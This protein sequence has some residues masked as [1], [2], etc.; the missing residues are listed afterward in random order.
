[1]SRSHVRLT[2]PQNDAELSAVKALFEDYA[3]S[4]NFSLAFQDFEQEMATFPAK[5]APPTGALILATVDD[6]PAGAVA[7][8]Q[9]APSI[10]E[11][12]RLY[13]RP[14]FRGHELGRK[15]AEAIVAEGKS[16]GYRA[17]RLDTFK[18][19]MARAKALYE[20]MGFVE[21]EP[22][23]DNPMPDVCYMEMMLR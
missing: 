19:S 17:M 21:V 12:K 18:D 4:L 5:Y 8:W 3:R 16:L 23:Y 22:Y 15:L 14:E 11:M 20:R 10:C 6:Q 2:K 1:M 7:L 13:V 9:Q